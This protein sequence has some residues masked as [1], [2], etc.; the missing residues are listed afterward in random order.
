MKKPFIN[1]DELGDLRMPPR[2]AADK[3]GKGPKQ[4]IGGW[5]GQARFYNQV[6]KMEAG[7]T[8]N[9]INCFDTSKED[10]VLDVGCGPGRVTVPMAKRAKKVTS[11]DASPKMLEFCRANAE[12]AGLTNVETRLLDWE[13]EESYQSLEKHDIVIA[14]RSVGMG[15][16]HRLS[17]LAKKY[18][19]IIIW[20][21][22]YPSIPMITGELF[23]GA[24]KEERPPMP[25]MM[26]DRRLGNNLMYNRIYDLGYNPNLN[27][28]EDGFTKDYASREEAYADLRKLREEIDE[29]K[30]DV[31]R[32]NV[33]KFLTENPDGTVT[34]LAKTKSI[35]LWWKPEIED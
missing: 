22:G 9:Q 6:A 35:V 17:N 27:I 4:G 15:D 25:Q 30:I 26:K 11:I 29:T 13:D 16:I 2:P 5:D 33:D 21:Y 12:A 34:Y 23:K 19:V 3:N 20:C 8:L 18:A 7:Y 24:E 28:V 14:S 1:W 10:T 32:A 31:F